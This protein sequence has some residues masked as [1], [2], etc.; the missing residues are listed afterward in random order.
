MQA[1]N[2]G[3]QGLPFTQFQ[4]NAAANA[5]SA[6]TYAMPEAAAAF[7]AKRLETAAQNYLDGVS[8]SNPVLAMKL[9]DDPNFKKN[10]SDAE[11]Y[12]K[13]R[14]AVRTRT[15]HL[16][17][18]NAEKQILGVLKDENNLLTKSLTSPMPYAD[19]QKRLDEGNFSLPAKAYFLKANGY[20]AR[21][22]GKLS[23]SEQLQGKAQLY[24]EMTN[25]VSNPDLKTSDISAFQ[26]K[27]YQAMDNGTLDEKNGASML[28]QIVAP[29]VAK[30]EES[31]KTFS[32]NHWFSDDI[33]FKGVK[34]LMED[35]FS[36]PVPEAKH[37]NLPTQEETLS[38]NTANATN[39]AAKVKM[40]DYYMTALEAN[41]KSLDV[42]VGDLPSMPPNQS[43][44][45]YAAAQ[46]EA[47]RLFMLDKHPALSTLND[48]PNQIFS[49]G[50]LIQGMAG[51]RKVKTDAGAAPTFKIQRNEKGEL[52][53]LYPDGTTEKMK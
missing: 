44:A 42:K 11:T 10:F 18:I 49:N 9:V 50:T 8:E 24:T 53:R 38:I 20:A 31:F 4:H 36:V 47:K 23:Q 41:A 33:G 13:T 45:V 51:T 39:N 6:A 52:R 16:Q 40:Y 21:A 12:S 19:L 3:M 43:R 35:E 5:V 48:I 27:I 32:E 26:E 25:L 7:G 29:M 15:L 46:A 34:Q 2:A 28:D 1:Y 17:E 22:E 37:K 14:T 30:K